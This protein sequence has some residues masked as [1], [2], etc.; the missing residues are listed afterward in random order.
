MNREEFET[1]WKQIRALATDRWSLVSD[2]DLLKIDKADVKYDKLVTM[3]RVKYGY[4]SDQAKK[5]LNKRL[6]VSAVAPET[7]A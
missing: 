4:T 7:K 6:A 5:E 1:N 3:L 2:Y